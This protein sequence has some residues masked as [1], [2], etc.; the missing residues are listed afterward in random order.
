MT[1]WFYVRDGQQNGPVTLETL[2]ELARTGGLDA[3]RDSVWNETMSGW[4]LAGLVPGIFGV[5]ASTAIP[6]INPANP[7]AAPHS[8]WRTAVASSRGPLEEIEHGSDPIDPIECIK[9]GMT[10]V[11]RQFLNIF[12]VGLVYFACILGISLAAN[13]VQIMMG[14]VSQTPGEVN[15]LLVLIIFVI[16]VAAQV[17]MLFLQ[18]GLIRIGLNLVSGKEA[19]VGVLIGMMFGEGDKLLRAVL[20]SILFAIAFVIGFV[21][22]I[23]PGIYL[24]LRYGHFLTA[25]VDRDLGVMESFDYSSSITTNNRVNRLLL[26]LLYLLGIIPIILTCY[27]GAIYIGPVIWL[28]GLVAYRWMQYGRLAKEDHPGTEIP[29]LDNL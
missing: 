21:C 13:F 1:D 26:G 28:T 7:Y 25:I 6:P 23:F 11:N 24:L 10:L 29:M 16:Q 22:L 17:A 2:I 3:T 18:L 15:W 20:A 5:S 9:R 19:S 8:A 27:I 14:S 4:T 12:L